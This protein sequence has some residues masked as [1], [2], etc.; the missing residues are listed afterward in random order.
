[1][2]LIQSDPE[3]DALSFFRHHRFSVS[4]GFGL[5]SD[6]KCVIQTGKSLVHLI[7]FSLLIIPKGK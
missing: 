4:S 6:I 2:G 3:A 5:L 1:M 7:K